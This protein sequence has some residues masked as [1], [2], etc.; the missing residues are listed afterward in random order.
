ARRRWPGRARRGGGRAGGGALS[1]NGARD[2]RRLAARGRLAE[3]VRR[4]LLLVLSVPGGQAAAQPEVAIVSDMVDQATLRRSEAGYGFFRPNR[5][6]RPGSVRI[7]SAPHDLPGC[8]GVVFARARRD[9]PFRPADV[10]LL[11][12]MRPLLASVVG[13]ARVLEDL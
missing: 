12:R 9:P 11:A 3:R 2:R 10:D 8:T 7:W 4:A 13:R 1:D 6:E 5:I